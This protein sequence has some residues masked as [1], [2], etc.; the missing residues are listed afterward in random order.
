MVIYVLSASANSGKTTTLNR[1]ANYMHAHPAKYVIG[2]GV[3]TPPIL[4]STSDDQYW[5]DVRGCKVQRVGISTAGDTPSEIRSAFNYFVSNACDVGFVASRT[6]G[7]TVDEIETQCVTCGATPN[8]CY[9]PY[10]SVTAR[11]VV[12]MRVVHFLESLIV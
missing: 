4:P 11:P 5:F 7:A 6:Y 12:Q 10:P 9:L 1:L 2:A 8:Y 3:P